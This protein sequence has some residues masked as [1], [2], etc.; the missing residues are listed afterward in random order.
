MV[1]VTELRVLLI[2]LFLPVQSLLSFTYSVHLHARLERGMWQTSMFIACLCQSF[3]DKALWHRTVRFL[4]KSSGN[5]ILYLQFRIHQSL[6]N[7]NT[8]FLFSSSSGFIQQAAVALICYLIY[9]YFYLLLIVVQCGYSVY[10]NPFY[11]TLHLSNTKSGLQPC[12][13][14]HHLMDIGSSYLPYLHW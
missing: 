9:N 6:E 2:T 7:S 8:L 5:Y 10:T 14:V 12:Y 1:L 3:F 4:P 11:L 13:D